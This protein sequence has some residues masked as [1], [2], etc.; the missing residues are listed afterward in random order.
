M[1]QTQ[2][3]RPEF[4]DKVSSRVRVY[5][6]TVTIEGSHHHP[7]G[8]RL[9][10]LLR[11]QATG[12]KYMLLTDARLTTPDGAESTAAF[13]LINTAHAAVILPLEEANQTSDSE[14]ADAPARDPLAQPAEPARTAAEKHGFGLGT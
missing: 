1:N 13:V 4:V 5:T 3:G 7:P 11:N 6:P 14:W 8:V 12:E 10:D 2:M 9:S